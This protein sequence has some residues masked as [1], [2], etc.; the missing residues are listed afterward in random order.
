MAMEPTG[1]VF[2]I[3]RFSLFDGPG[4]RTTVFLKG[5][6]LSCWWCHNPESQR[7]EPQLMYSAERCSLC[8]ACAPAC[9]EG[10][11]ALSDAGVTTL[12]I[13]R[14]CGACIEVC[15][16]GAREL[17]GRR[18]TLSEV[19]CEI[20]KD[21][22]FYDESGGG[23]SISGGEP[24][25]Q[26][27]FLD[28]LLSACRDRRIHTVIDTCGFAAREHL[29]QSSEKADLIL[30]DLKVMHPIKHRTYTGADN[31]RILDNLKS[32]I[33]HKRPLVVRIPIIPGI[34]DGD[35]DVSEMV[36]YLAS[37][38][39]ERVDLLP[40]HG[41]G[42]GKY[43]RLGTVYRLEGMRPPAEN[44]MQMIAERFNRAGI[45]VMSGGK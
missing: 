8:G 38:G 18:M 40:Y 16:T 36:S 35:A 5:C 26:P 19:M 9:P 17:A 30:F 44:R 42:V 39:T 12:S 1:V 13:C 33:E 37:V 10:A 4:I 28:A 34:N 31:Q 45:Q 43:R 22:I 15:P 7:A 23:V 25:L 20:E 2:N 32:L 29:L 21:V 24:F 14:G 3:M 41:T 11:I 27:L 6:P